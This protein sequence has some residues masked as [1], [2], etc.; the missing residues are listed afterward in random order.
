M[1][2]VTLAARDVKVMDRHALMSTSVRDAL[3]AV[4][5]TPAVITSK[6]HTSA[7][8]TED[9]EKMDQLAMLTARRE[10]HFRKC[11]KVRRGNPTVL[12][13]YKKRIRLY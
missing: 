11:L 9:T 12:C 1:H 6:V 13:N 2:S 3:T 7:T 10:F 5:V 8:A 4:T